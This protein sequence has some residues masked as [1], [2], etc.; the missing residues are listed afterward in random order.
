M[1]ETYL[2]I[3]IISYFKELDDI[4]R[5]GFTVMT[6]TTIGLTLFS[7]IRPQFW[8]NIGIPYSKSAIMTTRKSLECKRKAL[9]IK[10]Q[11]NGPLLQ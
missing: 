1:G 6:N 7:C 2:K 11:Q 5:K 10:F 9:R 3:S 4:M 8:V